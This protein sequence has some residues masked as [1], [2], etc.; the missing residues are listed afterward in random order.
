[1]EKHKI[2]IPSKYYENKGKL[3]KTIPIVLGISGL[4]SIMT[5]VFLQLPILLKVIFISFGAVLIIL[6]PLINRAILTKNPEGKILKAILIIEYVIEKKLINLFSMYYN[7]LFAIIKVIFGIYTKSYFFIV[8][9]F[10]SLCFGFAKKSYFDGVKAAKDDASSDYKYYGRIAFFILLGGVIY[11]IYMGRLFFVPSDFN[12]GMYLGLGIAL[13]SF[14]EVFIAVKGFLKTKGVLTSA[15]K[16]ISL[17][18]SSLALSFTQVAITSFS[19]EINS[20]NGNAIGG[21]VFG[22]ICIAIAVYM[23]IKLMIFKHKTKTE[24]V[25]DEL[26]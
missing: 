1:M 11:S 16:C 18:S 22:G 3:A 19:S 20:S 26:I 9:A 2:E 12:Y 15:L 14:I 23:F 4:A 24:K 5:G 21:I 13:I 25:E 10:Y 17:A 7:L 6:A 8:S